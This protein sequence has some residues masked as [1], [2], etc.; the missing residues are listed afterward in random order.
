MSAPE[1]HL[2]VD[3]LLSLG[4]EDLARQCKFE[5]YRSGGPGGQKRNKTASAVKLTHMPSG[6]SAHSADFRSQAEN[7]VR[8]LHRL[9]VKFA[10]DVRT[11]VDSRGYEPPAWVSASR[12]QGKLTTNTKNPLYA[13]LAAHVLD[14]F[15]AVDGRIADAA[16]LLGVPSSNLGHFL[17]AEHTVW[18]VAAR[19]RAANHLPS[20]SKKG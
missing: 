17:K 13:R 20:L 8:A 19:I 1:G 3:A 18:A 5:A 14:V 7:R 15:A 4:E 6:I 9:R 16:A 11:P 10:T 12:V 2:N